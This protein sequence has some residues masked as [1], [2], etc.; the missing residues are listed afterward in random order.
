MV[1]VTI[2]SSAILALTAFAVKSWS[3][4]LRSSDLHQRAPKP[5]P[6]PPYKSHETVPMSRQL[7]IYKCDGTVY[8]LV[9]LSG[10]VT[11]DIVNNQNPDGSYTYHG[12]I[13]EKLSGSGELTGATY[14]FKA[15]GN[16]AGKAP[17]DPGQD[18]QA[19][20]KFIEVSNTVLIAR[21]SGTVYQQHGVM[22]FVFDDQG[23]PSLRVDQSFFRDQKAKCN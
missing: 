10:T 8:D 4:A 15:T 20:Q 12:H 21:G 3:Y 1:K 2:L 14:S 18:I 9:D 22:Y 16:D 19:N 7:T 23:V 17:H 6:S 11:Q 13:T 5:V